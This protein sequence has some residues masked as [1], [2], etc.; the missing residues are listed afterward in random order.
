MPISAKDA[1][2]K[3]C[4][5]QNKMIVKGNKIQLNFHDGKNKLVKKDEYK[6]GD[7][8]KISLADNKINDVFKFDKGN[9]SMIIG[10]SHIGR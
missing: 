6:T 3:L 5:I 7:V 2:W 1:E 8:L 9:V 4:R 10:G